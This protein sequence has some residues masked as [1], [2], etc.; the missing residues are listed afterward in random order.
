MRIF[1][2]AERT[3]IKKKRKKE[4]KDKQHLF[5]H[6]A[7]IISPMGNDGTRW[8]SAIPSPPHQGERCPRING[9]PV[10]MPPAF[11]SLNRMRIER[12]R[13]AISNRRRTPSGGSRSRGR[14]ADFARTAVITFRSV[15]NGKREREGRAREE[16]A[17]S[18]MNS[19]HA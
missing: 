18:L 9:C 4:R 11:G 1:S 19:R 6:L 12:E 5:L 10:K 17:I 15:G 3:E 2:F 8:C 14:S 7:I 16:G 13:G